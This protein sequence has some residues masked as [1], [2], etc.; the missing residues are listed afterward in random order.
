MLLALYMGLILPSLLTGGEGAYA[1]TEVEEPEITTECALVYCENTD[2][3]IY[4]KNESTMASPFSTTKLLTAY[5]VVKYLSLDDVITVSANAA[6]WAEEDEYSHIGLK[7]GETLTV[8]QLLYGLMLESGNDAAVALAEAISG[9]EDS[10]AMLMTATAEDWGCTNTNFTNA[11]GFLGDN[12][13]TTAEDLLIIAREAFRNETVHQICSTL[14]YTIPAT[15][16]SEARE[17]RNTC[18]LLWEED[19]DTVAAKTGSWDYEN[20]VVVEYTRNQL[21]FIAILL[22]SNKDVR[23][24]DAHALMQY[25]LDCQSKVTLEKAGYDAGSL[26]VTGGEKTRTHAYAKD[27]VWVYVPPKTPED[28]I[29]L[30]P[31]LKKAAHAPLEEGDRVGTLYVCVGGVQVNQVELIAGESIG[32]GWFPSQFGVSNTATALTVA[33]TVLLLI[34]SGIRNLL[35]WYD[36]KDDQEHQE[37]V[38]EMLRQRL[39]EEE[40]KK[41]HVEKLP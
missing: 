22:R 28:V 16:L 7:A 26:P 5:L 38:M 3:V 40:R 39:E 6:R 4:Q 10:F 30:E 23:E 19:Q 13:Y 32:K 29:T 14:T 18:R 41:N 24:N 36:V 27:D 35:V 20:T 9:D 21:T 12:H 25:S 17:M 1:T 8:E 15:N 31:S 37:L 2:Q 34:I 33:V 11:S